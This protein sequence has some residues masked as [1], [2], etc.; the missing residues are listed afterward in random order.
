MKLNLGTKQK[1]VKMCLNPPKTNKQKT[2][3]IR[4]VKMWKLSFSCSGQPFLSCVVGNA[5]NTLCI[6]PGK[7]Q[8]LHS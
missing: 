3:L 4:G 1:G 8:G 5:I 2:L 6:T 7:S